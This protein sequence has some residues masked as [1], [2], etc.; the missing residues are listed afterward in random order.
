[1]AE[2]LCKVVAK[3]GKVVKL[4]ISDSTKQNV[5]NRIKN[6]RIYSNNGKKGW[7]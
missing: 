7:L 4:R 3:T 5:I 1:M 6:Q 2:Y